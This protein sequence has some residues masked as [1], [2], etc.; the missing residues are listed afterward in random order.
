MK[1]VFVRTAL[2]V[3][4]NRP[5]RVNKAVASGAD[6]VIIDLED[7]V[8]SAEKESARSNVHEKILQH[9]D[10][11]I[12]VRVSS[13]GSELLQEDLTELVGSGLHCIMLPKVETAADIQEINKIL[14]CLEKEKGIQEGATSV[15]HS[16]SQPEACKT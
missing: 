10:R 11:S 6:A 7:A 5:D 1:L 15:I 2:F 12:I 14:L 13:L 8:P 3:P 4:G 9:A 16:S